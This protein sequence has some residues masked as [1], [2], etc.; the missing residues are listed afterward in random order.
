MFRRALSEV[1]HTIHDEHIAAILADLAQMKAEH[2]QAQAA[3][4]IKL[5]GKINQLESRLQSQ[6]RKAQQRRE[7][8]QRVAWAK[9]E[10]LRAKAAAAKVRAEETHV[11]L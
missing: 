1:K 2:A 7:V 8:A 4:K 11:K 5:E 6:I 9:A 3:R 10:I